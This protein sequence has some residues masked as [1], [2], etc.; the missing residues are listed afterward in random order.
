MN[1]NQATFKQLDK[2]G[3]YLLDINIEV[4]SDNASCT[5]LGNLCIVQLFAQV[6]NGEIKIITQDEYEELSNDGKYFTYEE[7]KYMIENSLYL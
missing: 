4:P 6:V 2:N 5:T 3:N 1:E 7:F